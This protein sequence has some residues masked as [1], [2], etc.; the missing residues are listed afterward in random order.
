MFL[1]TLPNHPSERID[2]LI[3]VNSTHRGLSEDKGI[4]TFLGIGRKEDP[5]KR[6]LSM[7]VYVTGELYRNPRL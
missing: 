3:D 4:F 6:D 5:T 2:E 7:Q 1:P